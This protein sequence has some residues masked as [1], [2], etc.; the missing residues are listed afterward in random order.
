MLEQA[1]SAQSVMSYLASSSPSPP[2]ITLRISL[3]FDRNCRSE[4]LARSNLVWQWRGSYLPGLVDLATLFILR[5]MAKLDCTQSIGMP[6]PPFLI[7]LVSF[8]LSCF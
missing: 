2:P 1:S 7:V 8:S 6:L 3:V 4:N 5:L